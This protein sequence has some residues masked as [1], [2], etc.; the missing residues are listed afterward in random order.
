MKKAATVGIAVSTAIW[1]S[2]A[3][4]IVPIAGAQTLTIE[5]LQ[6]QIAQLLAQIQALQTQLATQ[7][8]APAGGASVS[9]SFTRD[10]TVGAKGDDVMC[11]QKTLNANGYAVAASGAGSPG[12]ESSYFGPATKAALAKFQAAKGVTPSVGYF[13]PKT[14]TA[15]A[16]VA[17]PVAGG[18]TTPTTPGTTTSPP[19][20]AGVTIPSTGV[21]IT[22][23]SD[24]PARRALPKAASGIVFL[25]FNLAGTG[26]VNSL[27]FKREGIG[28]TGD[29]TSGGVYLYDGGTRL[30]SGRTINSTTHEIE[31]LNLNI[32]LSGSVKTL[33]LVADV[34]GGATSGNRSSFKLVSAK[35]DPTPTGDIA[36]NE[37]EIAGQTVGGLDP[38]SGAGPANPRIG[39][40]EALLQEI[41]LTASSTEDVEVKRI[42][43][44][45]TGTIQN[46]HLSNFILKVNDATIAKADA[47][48]AKDLVTFTLDKPYTIEKG[49]QRTFKI[50]GDI[51]GKA[52]SSDTVIL[53]FDSASDI[54]AIGKLYGYPV[55]PTITALDGD[56]EADTLTIQ[57][58]T[59]TITFNGPIAG[60]A[61]L[62]GQDINVFD[63]TL[64]TQNN[65]EIKNLRFYATTTEWG[66]GDSVKFADF[67]VW[68]I[69]KNS[70]ITSA[71]DITA[72]STSQTFTDTIQMSAGESRRFKVTVDV[73]SG[74]ETGDSIDIALLAFQSGD[75][76]NLD[77]NTNVATGDI[78]PSTSLDG[79]AH[80][81]VAPTLTLQLAGSPSSQTFVRGTSKVPLVGFSFQA[82]GADI[83]LTS[84][85]VTSTAT[86]ATLGLGEI[87]NLA[88]YDGETRVSDEKSLASDFSV[89]F[90]NLNLTIKKGETKTLVVK[91]NLSANADANDVYAISVSTAGNFADYITA[92][93]PD[94][95]SAT[96]NGTRANSGSTVAITVTDVGNVN[97]A[98]AA[99]DSESEAGIIV[100]GTE[101][102]IGKFKFTATNEEITV[103]K[104]HVFIASSTNTTPTSTEPSNYAVDEVP[105]IKLYEG[106][107]QI[108]NAA[109]YPVTNS[110]VSS[111]VAFVDGLNWKVPKNGNKILTIKGV[112]NSIANGADTGA[113][114][115]AHVLAAGFESQGA[116]AKDLSIDG[117][118]SNE[119]IVYKT[120]PVITLPTQPGNKLGS[121]EVPVLRF[122]IAADAGAEVS[123]KKISLKVSMTGATM[124]AVDA[125]PGTTGNI[126]LKELTVTNSNLNIVSA[127][128]SPGTA[129]STQ[130]AIGVALNSTGYVSL[131]L[132][133]AETVSAGSFKDYE[134]ALTFVNLASAAGTAYG[135][136]QLYLQETDNVTSSGWSGVEGIV[137]G[138]GVA[139]ADHEPSFIW[140]DNSNTSHTEAT[141]DW[142]NGRYV[143]TLPSDQK[144]VSN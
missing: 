95:N 53:R 134:V 83:K 61:A 29:F 141:F 137:G 70:V 110:G 9:C 59:V 25:K 75:I 117:A 100:A 68:D 48:G 121:G 135:T 27:T 32:N 129:S 118:S 28:A 50:Y 112:L 131:I 86:T 127:Y 98:R 93:D 57:G 81:V 79:N 94:G 124:S 69:E 46:D 16:S 14:R 80:T 99:D 90:S 111:G 92:T 20:P 13:G 4:A 122:R 41:I 115:Y 82:T 23:A 89:T 74:N 114:V 144:T 60:D 24:N 6:A 116:T 63:F 113:S 64:A 12:N 105:T 34:A 31:F 119:K 107:L 22:L 67:K 21:A 96:V 38:T 72:T 71:V 56:S 87:Q 125:A 85:K 30:T 88:L 42:A 33:T 66:Q 5:Q 1:L 142:N 138:T 76:K 43:V 139:T 52:R 55:L 36:G 106:A 8:G 73:S 101:S 143:K 40:K 37:M 26:K 17:A 91:G 140:S 123:W 104:M 77:N 45:E 10:L 51:G 120:K 102:V 132:N 108:G 54:Y 136:F 49:Q 3:A 103:N 19:A 128:S 2:G 58:G 35:G 11:L 65:I 109:G 78:V 62:R 39:Q 130:N 84:V 97:I 15:I 18:T 44:I 47:I 7:T 126:K 133:S